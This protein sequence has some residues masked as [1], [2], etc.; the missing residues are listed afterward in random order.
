MAHDQTL[1]ADVR[2]IALNP[3]TKSNVYLWR[4][5]AGDTWEITRV[6]TG[7]STGATIAKIYWTVKVAATDTDAAAI[8]QVSITTTSTATGQII[9]A[10]SNG[11]S[12]ELAIIASKAQTALIT[13]G[14]EYVYDIVAIDSNGG[15]YT[16]E[17]G[18]I[19]A[20]QGVT[21]ATT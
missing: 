19:C 3:L 11:G 7:L 2:T 8:F 18:T 20:Q 16:L 14:Q 10:N 13:P 1:A 12:I 9:D 6:Y 17:L 4:L 15:A 21:V 5:V